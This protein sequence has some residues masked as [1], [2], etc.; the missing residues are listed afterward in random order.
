[1]RYH[2]LKF[3]PM[4]VDNHRNCIIKRLSPSNQLLNYNQWC[5]SSLI[6]RKKENEKNLNF[7]K[8]KNKLKINFFIITTSN[9]Q[10]LI[11]CT[12]HFDFLHLRPNQNLFLFRII[13]THNIVTANQRQKQNLKYSICSLSNAG[14]LFSGIN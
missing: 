14:S 10:I 5:T 12:A 7:E 1:M 6:R 9:R 11:K 2:P 8:R 3:G 4:V 13:S